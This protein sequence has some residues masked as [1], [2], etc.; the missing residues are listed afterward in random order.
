MPPSRRG[1]LARGATVLAFSL[2]GCSAAGGCIDNGGGAGP[3]EFEIRAT[4]VNRTGVPF[5]EADPIRYAD[6]PARE[7][8]VVDRALDEESTSACLYDL[9]ESERAALESFARRV[10]EHHHAGRE[11][12]YLVREGEYFEVYVRI[13]DRLFERTG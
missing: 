1:V 10:R 11:T 3:D 6:L 12:T 8:Q 13:E 4:P 2:A 5:A 9:S 7:R